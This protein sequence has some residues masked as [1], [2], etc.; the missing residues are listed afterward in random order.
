MTREDAFY[1][2]LGTI[3][4]VACLAIIAAGFVESHLRLLWLLP[5]VLAVVMLLV[6]SFVVGV[7]MGA[8]AKGVTRRP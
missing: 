6:S 2:A 5:M 7:A 8:K 1:L 4:F 3:E